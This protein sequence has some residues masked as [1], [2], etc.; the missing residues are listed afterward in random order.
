MSNEPL[1]RYAVLSRLMRA[2]VFLGGVLVLFLIVHLTKSRMDWLL[3]RW[4]RASI[5]PFITANA[6][7]IR[8]Y[9]PTVKAL[10]F[11]CAVA[12]L[13][14]PIAVDAY[15]NLRTSKIA[16]VVRLIFSAILIWAALY[17]LVFRPVTDSM[18]TNYAIIARS[19]FTQDSGIHNKRLLMP[20]L[21]Y[22]FYLRD[23]Q[24][25]Y[26]FSAALTIG[27]I[28]LLIHWTSAHAP[29]SLWQIV[30]LCT[31]SFVLFQYEY[32]GYPDILVYVLII[33]VM[34][35][36]T[37]PYSKLSLL[38]LA[39]LTHE[40]SVLVGVILAWRY[41]DRKRFIFYLLAVMSYLLIW[42]FVSGQDLDVML[43]GHKV[44][45]FSGLAWFAAAPIKAWIGVLV[46]YKAVWLLFFISVWISVRQRLFPDLIFMLAC[47]VA[48]IF[49]TVL[50]VDTS[51]LMGFAFPGFL[52]ALAVVTKYLEPAKAGMILFP[53]FL[54]NLLLPSFNIGL[55]SGIEFFPGLYQILYGWMAA[56]PQYTILS[57]LHRAQVQVL[58][59]ATLAPNA[60]RLCSSATKQSPT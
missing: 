1:A 53:I 32:G 41:L 59:V 4:T 13:C 6:D 10:A 36:F 26:M 44:E 3:R 56:L 55:N 28:A 51:R 15:R 54:V 39:M 45:G 47:V 31:C 20:A 38:I 27:F 2:L 24:P 8:A 57:H 25:Y 17:L 30:S 9:A 48:G 58:R 42:F 19:P 35:D 60:R 43:R 21:A 37:Q 46:A 34:Q 22:L 18:G 49:M 5:F 7:L 29:L 16:E 11:F 23:F 12:I 40:A 50:G 14:I 33:L 52:V